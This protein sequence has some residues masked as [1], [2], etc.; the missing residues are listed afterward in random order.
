V[1]E[2]RTWPFRLAEVVV[3][4]IEAGLKS[5]LSS[6]G[7]EHMVRATARQ[8]VREMCLDLPPM[9]EADDFGPADGECVCDRCGLEYRFHP[10]DPRIFSN[11]G[12][13]F[14]RILCDGRRV[15]L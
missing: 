6:P 15:K 2:P 14:L 10:A 12:D 3:R 7:R 11:T 1:D 8:A 4:G 9:T 5:P 13:L